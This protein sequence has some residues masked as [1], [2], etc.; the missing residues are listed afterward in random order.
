MIQRERF[1]FASFDAWWC[2]LSACP[3]RSNRDTQEPSLQYAKPS[4]DPIRPPTDPDDYRVT[5]SPRFWRAIEYEQGL[6]AHQCKEGA[7]ESQH[8]VVDDLFPFRVVGGSYTQ[9]QALN[10]HENGRNCPP[11]FDNMYG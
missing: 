9:H 1:F 7:I 8:P 2:I 6:H 4:F 3:V 10:R 5:I 11:I